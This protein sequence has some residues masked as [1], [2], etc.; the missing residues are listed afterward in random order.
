MFEARSVKVRAE[1]EQ[2][3]PPSIAARI[4]GTSAG[5]AAAPFVDFTS[6]QIAVLFVVLTAI[7]SIPILLHPWLP[8]ADYMNHLAR[9]YI[10]AGIG[11]DPEITHYYEIDWQLIPNLMMDLIVPPLQRLMNVYVAGQ[12]YI[13]LSFVLIMSGT[14]A[15]NRQLFGRWSVLPLIAFPLLYN[16]VFLIGTLNYV[17]G[18]GI[19]LWA[20]AV[21][22]QLRER[23]L[24][25]RLA[26]SAA[27]VAALYL[28]HL[29]ALGVYGLGLL[30]YELY[31][32]G[33]IYGAPRSRDQ[34]LPMAPLV[35]FVAT[36][37]PFLPV[38][39]LLLMSPTWGLR[40]VFNWELAGKL[41]GLLFVVEAYSQF[42]G[43][44]LTGVVAF[45]AGWAIRQQ[46]LKFHPF[47][48]V[49]LAVGGLAYFAMPRVIFD[50]YMADQRM[51]I[52]IAFMAVAC[53]HINMRHPQVRRGFA[54]VLVLLLAIR[55]FEVETAWNDMSRVTSSF[56]ESVRQI[57]RGAKVMV[58]Y[59]DTQAG[60][61][62]RDLPLVHAASLAV[63]ERGALVST[64]FTVP[65]KQVLRARA[66]YR[67]QVDTQ[68]GTPPGI[69]E[70]LEAVEEPASAR[71]VYWKRW[72]ADYDYLYV[73]FTEASYENP[74]PELL[75]MVYMGDRFVL[76]RINRGERR[77]SAAN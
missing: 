63:I 8:L 17:F 64:N 16:K 62:S 47:G 67:A 27:F 71:D 57:E 18:I 52:A 41:D 75:T 31:R 61:E 70:L 74:E 48:F 35:D 73:L 22:V 19:A 77:A 15:L 1:A 68:D 29:F 76:Y 40:G 6:R 59:G 56:R 32:L 4:A 25:L 34:R 39:P 3:L 7:M 9:M 28:C 60:E 36:G 44:A 55:V 21:W 30:A 43:L 50:T 53:A 49:L 46:A 66:S 58:A 33:T 51:P 12:V 14:L 10:I 2:S 23:T 38:L 26:A 20:L 72:T 13:A 5:S 69:E 54:T 37:L 45:A 42:A 24:V 65:G 11:T